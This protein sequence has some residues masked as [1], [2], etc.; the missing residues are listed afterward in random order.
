MTEKDIPPGLQIYSVGTRLAVSAKS[1]HVCGCTVGATIGRLL[2]NPS[3]L[4]KM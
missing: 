1:P 3:A 4:Q 2:K